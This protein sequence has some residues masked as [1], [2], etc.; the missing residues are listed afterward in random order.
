M[1]DVVVVVGIFIDVVVH[2]GNISLFMINSI[3]ISGDYSVV[4]VVNEVV[5]LLLGIVVEMVV[6][7]VLHTHVHP[8]HDGKFSFDLHTNPSIDSRGGSRSR[9][10]SNSPGYG[11]RNGAG[12]AGSNGRR[13]SR[14]R[15]PAE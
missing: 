14:S 6:D 3:F 13:V 7:L 5:R 15:S 12:R 1:V 10:K 2:E 9:S 8:F 11:K 4:I